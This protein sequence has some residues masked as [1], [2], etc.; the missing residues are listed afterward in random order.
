ME[1]PSSPHAKQ[2]SGNSQQQAL[3]PIAPPDELHEPDEVCPPLLPF[4]SRQ[5]L[6]GLVF[7]A[8]LLLWRP[9]AQPNRIKLP[10]IGSIIT[11]ALLFHHRAAYHVRVL[12][13]HRLVCLWLRMAILLVCFSFTKGSCSRIICK[14]IYVLGRVVLLVAD[15]LGTMKLELGWLFVKDQAYV[16][17]NY[18]LKF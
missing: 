3:K 9:Y 1:G 7:E 16:F 10:Y 15:F 4:P 11:G 12:A 8:T 17:V 6:F 18:S 13:I 2:K 14:H 5:K